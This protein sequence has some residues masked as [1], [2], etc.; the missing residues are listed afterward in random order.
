MKLVAYYLL[1]SLAFAALSVAAPDIAEGLV[2]F[3]IALLMV[4]AVYDE[5][6]RVRR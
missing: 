3:F 2:V 5:W 4:P 6:L 1:I